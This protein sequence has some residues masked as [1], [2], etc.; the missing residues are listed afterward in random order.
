MCT[1]ES[2]NPGRVNRHS[3][4]RG[5]VGVRVVS[6]LV[7]IVLDVQTRQLRE[8]DSQRAAAI[9]DV[10]SVQGLKDKVTWGCNCPKGMVLLP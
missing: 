4:T 8:V 9:V 5:Q 7:V 10:L 3:V 6:A 1:S 2:A